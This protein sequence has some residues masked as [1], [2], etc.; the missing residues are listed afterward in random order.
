MTMTMVNFPL[1]CGLACFFTFNGQNK[2]VTYPCDPRDKP[3]LANLD[4]AALNMVV[5]LCS[6]NHNLRT[7]VGE[8]GGRTKTPL[9]RLVRTELRAI[10]WKG[11]LVIFGFVQPQATTLLVL[12]HTRYDI[13]ILRLRSC[14]LLA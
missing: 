3:G 13:I 1:C 8:S 14:V 7:A 9:I 5:V 12:T 11:I 2:Y 6:K 10:A 4:D